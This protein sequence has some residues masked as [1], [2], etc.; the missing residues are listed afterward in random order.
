[1]ATKET[2]YVWRNGKQVTMTSREVKAYIMKAN[3]W[4]SEQYRKQYD[5]FKNK[6]RAY[7]SYKQAQGVAEKPQSVVSVLFKEAKA[8]RQYGPNYTPS[9]KMQQ[10]RG[11]KAYSI[12]KGRKMATEERYTARETEKYGS[13]IKNRFG[14][15]DPKD[16]A[17][18]DGFIGANKGAQAIV[19]R[20][21]QQAQESGKPINYAKMEKAL[22]D[23][24]DKVHA[25]ITENEKVEENEAIHYGE[26]SGSPDTYVDFDI[27]EYI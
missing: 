8:K 25:K 20:F 21:T 10:I 9:Q 26:A 2:F 23:Y 12:T 1:M 16:P 24:A 14:S 18:N 5:I 22:S 11:F 13:Y 27:E 4:T 19:Q 7:E 3:G 15:Y 17:K 6:L